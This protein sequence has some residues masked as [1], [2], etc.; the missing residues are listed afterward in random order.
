MALFP[1][2]VAVQVKC[3]MH[4]TKRL[5]SHARYLRID[6]AFSIRFVL[7][8]LC[9]S[10]CAV[11]HPDCSAWGLCAVLG[12]T[13]LPRTQRRYNGK[14]KRLAVIVQ[15]A[16]CIGEGQ[17]KEPRIFHRGAMCLIIRDRVFPIMYGISLCFGSVRF[18]SVRAGSR[19]LCCR[20]RL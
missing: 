19:G 12:V 17:N 8:W 5:K 15:S 14:I 1:R 18:G 7:F 9:C 3:T 11:F 20:Y 2:F 6:S 13:I 16:A 10:D 4:D